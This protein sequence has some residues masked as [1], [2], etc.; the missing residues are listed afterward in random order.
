MVQSKIEKRLD[1]RYKKKK[2]KEIRGTARKQV[3]TAYK[4]VSTQLI[5]FVIM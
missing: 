4:F 1:L 3:Y 5:L 2:E